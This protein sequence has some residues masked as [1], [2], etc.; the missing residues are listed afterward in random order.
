M[1]T[2]RPALL[3]DGKHVVQPFIYIYIYIY[4]KIGI[5][6]ESKLNFGEHIKQVSIK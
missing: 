5:L 6:L 2:V 1:R 4:K 3:F